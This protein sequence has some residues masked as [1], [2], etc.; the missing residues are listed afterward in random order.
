MIIS[1][2][3]AARYEITEDVHQDI[4]KKLGRTAKSGSVAEIDVAG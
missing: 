3:I 2:F 1:F 4:L